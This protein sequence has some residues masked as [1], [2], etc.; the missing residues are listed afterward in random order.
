[1]ILQGD[2]LTVLPTLPENSVHCVVTSPPYWSLR[3]YGV[4]PT[5]WGGNPRCEHEWVSAGSKEG[6]AGKD[7]WQHRRN[8][9]GQETAKH[10]HTTQIARSSCPEVWKPIEQGGFCRHC[11]AWRGVL[12]LEPT[13]ELYIEHIV[14]LFREVR[15]ILRKD[16]T[17]WVNLGDSYANDV[18]GSRG[19]YPASTTSTL[20]SPDY[21]SRAQHRV[22]KGWRGSGLRIKKKDLIGIPWLVAFALRDDG[23]Y[24]RRDIVWDKPNPKPESA[25]DRPSTS[26][27]YLFIFSKRANYYYDQVAVREYATYGNHK[28]RNAVGPVPSHDPHDGRP[29]TGLR[30]VAGAGAGRNCRSV[31][32]I[33]V[34]PYKEAHFAT[35]PEDLPAR[36]IRAATSEHGACA[37]CGAPFRR[38]VRKGDWN[39]MQLAVAG[40]NVKGEYRGNATK[41]YGRGAQN[42]SELKRRILAGMRERITIGWVPTCKCTQLAPPVPC[43]VH[44]P[45][46]GSGATGAAAVR[47]GR[48]F[49]GIE[50]NADYIEMGERRLA[51]AAEPPKVPRKKKARAVIVEIDEPLPFP[52]QETA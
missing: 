40:A 43:T 7:R 25:L 15:R 28:H 4:P 36:C 27:E 33:Q 24:L 49:V 50:L 31:W 8:G 20:G 46:S 35:F 3:D 19:I 45:M 29:H 51:K 30:E 5:V 16:G 17:L 41:A 11:G 42:A 14:L 39:P 1:M 52:D 23:W 26:H 2:C 18:K 9:K 21:E 48:A 12:G 37:S 47:L 22:Q 34:R 6:F 44:D 38:Q 13:P 32:R 10:R